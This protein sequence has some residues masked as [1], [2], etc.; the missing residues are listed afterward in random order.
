MSEEDELKQLKQWWD[1][2]GVS[3]LVSIVLAVGVVLGWQGWQRN[4][5]AKVEAGTYAFQELMQ[6]TQ[7]VRQAPDDIKIAKATRRSMV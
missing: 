1:D 5:A 3:T 7:E 6:V 4:Q 2:N